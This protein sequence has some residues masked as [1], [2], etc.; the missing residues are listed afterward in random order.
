MISSWKGTCLCAL[1]LMYYNRSGTLIGNNP[2][3][4]IV[5]Y[6]RV[7]QLRTSKGL[8]KVSNTGPIDLGPSKAKNTLIE[9]VINLILFK[10]TFPFGCQYLSDYGQLYLSSTIL[11]WGKFQNLLSC[12]P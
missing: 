5:K 3:L 4:P 8:E 6:N 2:I 11:K 1:S 10:S 9:K 7:H 12:Q